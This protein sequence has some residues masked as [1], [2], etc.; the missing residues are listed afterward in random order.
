MDIYRVRHVDPRTVAEVL[1]QASDDWDVQD[2]LNGIDVITPAR[3]T[4]WQRIRARWRK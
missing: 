3:V 1:Q 4:L 2:W